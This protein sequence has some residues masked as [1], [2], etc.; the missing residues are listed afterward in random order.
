LVTSA[1]VCKLGDFG[2]SVSLSANGRGPEIEL[3]GTP[4]YQ[5]P[6]L[7]KGEL[8]SKACDVYSFGI[9]LWQ[10]DSRSVP[11]LGQHPQVV[12]FQVVSMVARP[13]PPPISAAA[14]GLPA[15]TALYSK[16]WAARPTERPSMD[17]ITKNVKLIGCHTPIFQLRSLRWVLYF[18]STFKGISVVRSWDMCASQYFHHVHLVEHFVNQEGLNMSL[19][20]SNH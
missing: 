8:P 19:C 15:F 10:L 18:L 12:M 11:Y 20:W 17:S 16:C 2:C 14:V 3:A 4:G 1:G 7:L 13:Q 5:A 9:L 6:E